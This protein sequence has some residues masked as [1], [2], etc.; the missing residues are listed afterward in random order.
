MILKMII[1]AVLFVRVWFAGKCP[2]C[3]ANHPLN[4]VIAS[5]STTAATGERLIDSTIFTLISS[6]M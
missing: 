5:K 4:A 3:E 1:N 2:R 6:E